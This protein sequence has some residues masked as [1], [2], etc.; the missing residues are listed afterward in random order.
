MLPHMQTLLA[1]AALN[2]GWYVSIADDGG[3]QAAQRMYRF[4]SKSKG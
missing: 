4:H 3:P 2:E 1:V